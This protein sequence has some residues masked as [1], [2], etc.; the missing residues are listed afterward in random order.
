MTDTEKSI[1]I[2][3]QKVLMAEIN[4]SGAKDLGPTFVRVSPCYSLTTPDKVAQGHWHWQDDLDGA[5]GRNGATKRLRPAF[6]CFLL[7]L[8]QQGGGKTWPREA[9]LGRRLGLGLNLSREVNHLL[10]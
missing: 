7:A 1:C 10:P 5:A 2:S 6:F 3:A 9:E 4:E 8:G